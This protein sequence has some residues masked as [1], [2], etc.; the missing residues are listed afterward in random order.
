MAMQRTLGTIE[1]KRLR[2][3]YMKIYRA[4]PIGIE[5]VAQSVI[6]YISMKLRE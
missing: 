1:A 5:H 4:H 6:D 3:D 2:Q